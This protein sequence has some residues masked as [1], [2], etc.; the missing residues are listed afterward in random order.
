MWPFIIGIN[1]TF[2]C[3]HMKA[4]PVANFPMIVGFLMFAVTKL[5][6]GMS[7]DSIN[8][9]CK[10]LRPWCSYNFAVADEICLASND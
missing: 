4:K 10:S 7:L 5:C 9:M 3:T 1:W 2:L 8:A 6:K